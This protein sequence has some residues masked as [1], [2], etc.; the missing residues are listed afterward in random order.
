M[1]LYSYKCK[2][3]EHV[4]ERLR[5]MGAMDAPCVCPECKGNAKRLPVGGQGIIKKR[6]WI[7]TDGG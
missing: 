7:P 2:S 3:C 5:P 6:R 1:P 4:W